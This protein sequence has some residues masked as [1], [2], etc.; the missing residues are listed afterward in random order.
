MTEQLLQD[1]RHNSAFNRTGRIGV[2]QSVHTESLDLGLIAQLIQMSIVGTVFCRLSGAEID[3]HQISHAEILGFACAA[4]H[5]FKDLRQD[6][7][8]FAG[9]TF[10]VAR[11]QNIVR[12]ICQ[13]NGAVTAF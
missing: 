8:L 1:F 10:I 5:V 2:S 11:F 6:F 12:T 3:K 13:R 7:R 9:V 4:I